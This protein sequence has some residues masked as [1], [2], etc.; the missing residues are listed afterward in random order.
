MDSNYW[1]IRQSSNWAEMAINLPLI[2]EPGEHFM[3]DSAAMH[4]LSVILSHQTGQFA[5]QY[6]QQRL[7]RPLGI[8]VQQWRMD[9]QWNNEGC[10]GLAL[11]PRDMAKF[12]YLYLNR[13]HWNGQEIIPEWF[14]QESTRKHSEGGNPEEAAYGYLW[15]VRTDLPYPA[16]CASGY[17]G[18][19]IFVIPE[20]DLVIAT[21]CDST[22]VPPPEA[23]VPLFFDDIVPATFQER[24]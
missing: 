11:T 12:G 2:S 20:S 5:L 19:Y 8:D 10:S 14:I 18:Q 7:F 16:Y 23:P 24:V 1:L 15:W 9:P 21:T 22:V 6:A 13:G 3:Y 17:G 4:L